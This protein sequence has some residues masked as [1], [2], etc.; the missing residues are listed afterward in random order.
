MIVKSVEIYNFRSIR[1]AKFRFDQISALVGENNA[2]K[3][4]VLKA[5]NSFFNFKEEEEF[6]LNKSHNYGPKANTRIII[7]FKIDSANLP[8]IYRRYI[9]DNAIKLKFSYIYSL[10]KKEYHIVTN[11]DSIKIPEEDFLRIISKIE[12]V[13]IPTERGS[14]NKINDGVFNKLVRKYLE[15]Y[16]SNRDTISRHVRDANQMLH[17]NILSKL[18]KLIES[19]Y[20]TKDVSEF[21]IAAPNKTDYSILLDS[22][23]LSLISDNGEYFLE[24]YGS[25]TR[26]L[27]TIAMYRANAKLNDRIVILGIEEP[28]TNL[29]PQAQKKLINSLIN[30]VGTEEVQVIFTTHSTVL[31]DQLKHENILLVRK[32]KSS[33]SK[34]NSEIT[35]ISDS[36]W[37]N[38]NIEEFKHYQ[39]FHYK[40][41]DFFFS[42]YV[43]VCES[44]NDCQVIEKLLRD[45]LGESILDVSFL[46]AG[47]KE[48]IK[49]AYYLLREL[50]LPFVLIV[51]KDFFFNY[52]IN[53][54]LEDSRDCR[55]GLPKYDYTTLADNQLIEEIFG[56]NKS[57]LLNKSNYRDLF[58]IISSKNILSMNYCLEMDLTCSKKAREEYC[59]ILNISNSDTKRFELLSKKNAIKKIGTLMEVLEKIPNR[60][61]PES[62]QKIVNY[63]FNDIKKYI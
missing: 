18:E 52:Q 23:K 3:T 7:S 41:S 56:G 15:I 29:H 45:K 8:D 38:S 63:I 33:K 39:Y 62:Y 13:Y 19:L 25:G 20:F 58:N 10:N 50:Q 21:N 1:K 60:S 9:F 46:D 37:Q 14:I 35:Q 57:R 31:I 24:E 2:G 53:N 16:T 34:L 6:F 11:K 42:K 54:R 28:E 40:N 12:Y 5:L 22:L 26:S 51:D 4:A 27:A 36:F 55:T 61:L 48:N 32:S 43:V 30:S 47:G 49:Y 59:R 17:K 44:K